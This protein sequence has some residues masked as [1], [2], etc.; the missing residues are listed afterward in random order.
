M[1]VLYLS[2]D[3]GFEVG[4]NLML[5]SLVNMAVGLRG[6]EGDAKR[7]WHCRE[8]CDL[9]LW[10]TS[11][12]AVRKTSHAVNGVK[13]VRILAV[14]LVATKSLPRGLHG[15]DR[16]LGEWDAHRSILVFEVQADLVSMVTW[17]L[18]RLVRTPLPQ[19]GKH[20]AGPARGRRAWLRFVFHHRMLAVS[21]AIYSGEF[22]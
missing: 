9:A 17:Q 20:M 14:R 21:V 1:H 18:V 13:F 3:V 2:A 7:S 10:V 11:Y 15:V 6:L 5:E 8:R 4:G 16:L 22:G 19:L 12:K